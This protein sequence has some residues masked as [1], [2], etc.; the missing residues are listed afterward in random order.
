MRTL[1]DRGNRLLK[2][3]RKDKHDRRR[4]CLIGVGMGTGKRGYSSEGAAKRAGADLADRYGHALAP[5]R[6]RCGQWHLTTQVA[7]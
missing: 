6:C 2:T 5:Y 7:P 4:V 1:A 3:A